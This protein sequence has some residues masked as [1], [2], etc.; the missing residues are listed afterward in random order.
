MC[1]TYREGCVMMVT[2]APERVLVLLIGEV[3]EDPRVLRTCRSLTHQG[4]EVTVGCAVR[5]DRPATE[6]VENLRIIRFPYP[7]EFWLKRLYQVFQN[8]MNP[9]MT[10]QVSRL[11]EE[12]PRSHFTSSIRNAV[13]VLNHRHVL[14]AMR[15]ANRAMVRTFRDTVYD[16]AH[17]NDVDTLVA[18][19]ALKSA[20]FVRELVYDAHEFWPGIGVHGSAPNKTL[21]LIEERFIGD[22]DHVVT[23][24]DMIAGKLRDLYSLSAVPAVIMNCPDRYEGPVETSSIHQ[25]VRILYQGKLQAFRGLEELVLAFR[26]VPDAVL[27]IAG[28]GPMRERLEMVARKEGLAGRVVFTGRYSP[29]DAVSLAAGHDIGMLPFSPVTM[30]IQYAAPNKLFDY[31]MAGLAVAST[32]LPFLEPFITTHGIGKV[33]PENSPSAIAHTL[34]TLIADPAGLI[35]CKQKARELALSTYTWDRQFNSNYPWK[36]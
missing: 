24:N 15:A 34:N 31:L 14:R 22:A 21:K 7:H 8:K 35:A 3:L 4:A 12:T 26:E 13:L 11:H 17:C 29:E 20:G 5:N 9:L 6:T 28:W 19:S 1:E 18:G 33:F 36:P 10:R 25:P 30:S 16:M 27:T 23:V 2:N 32:G